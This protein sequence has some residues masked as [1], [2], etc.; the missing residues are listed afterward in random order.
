MTK[1]FFS[2]SIHHSHVKEIS[3][4]LGLSSTTNLGKYLGILFLH[5]QVT[6]G[7]L[8]YLVNKSAKKLFTY[9]ANILSFVG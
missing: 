1:V 4:E 2:M 8:S 7:T 9:K 6:K 5:H 3:S